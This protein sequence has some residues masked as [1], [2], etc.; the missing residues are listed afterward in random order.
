VC[1]L[2]R[3]RTAVWLPGGAPAQLACPRARFRVW[4]PGGAPAQLACSRAR[5]RVWFAGRWIAV[6]F[7]GRWIAVW[8][9]GGGALFGSPAVDRCLVLS[10]AH[11]PRWLPG[12][13]TA[14]P[15]G[16]A[17]RAAGVA[18][19][20]RRCTRGAVARSRP[21]SGARGQHC[22]T[23]AIAGAEHE[24][25]DSSTRRV[26]LLMPQITWWCVFVVVRESAALVG[27]NRHDDLHDWVGL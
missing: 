23:A 13:R 11:Q 19:G 18:G 12:Q 20:L 24:D 2:R 5:F 3:G 25:S 10:A 8:F 27:P 6:W 7:A 16:V 17:V 4:L 9:A 26:S 14:L 21:G 22:S 1:P 15:A